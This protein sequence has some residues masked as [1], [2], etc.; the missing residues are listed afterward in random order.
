MN[1]YQERASNLRRT[2]ALVLGFLVVV[3]AVG[4][5]ISWYYGNPLILYVA[6]MV[7]VATNFYA[8]WASD[9][10]VLSL[11]KARPATREEFF[12]LYTVTENMAIAAGL[13]TPKLY[14]ID[15]EAP[16]AFAT[17]RDENHA[18][19]CA[20]TGLLAL[21]SRPELEGVVA[22][23]LAHIKN[24]DMLVMT[25]AVVL[26]GFVA[27]LADIFLRTSLHG[28]F[29]SSDSKQG[30]VVLMIGVVVAII[31]APLAAKLIQFA[32]SRRREFLADASGALLT[33][34]PEGL[35]SALRKISGVN[36]PLTH[37]SH[38]TAHLFIDEPFGKAEGKMGWINGLFATHPPVEERIRAL[39]HTP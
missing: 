37:T 26:A 19:V 2:W 9:K 13:P 21:L 20:T 14:V 12:D 28:G 15:D 1:L 29:R 32:I 38:A 8:Y 33:R 34:H 36:R 30:N 27:I 11:N 17:G 35:A 3:I 24:R 39:T 10:L 23:E 6:V 16:N 5:A 31:L 7:A 18:V 25:V 4:Y 22:H